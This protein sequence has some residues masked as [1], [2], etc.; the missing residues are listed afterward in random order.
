MVPPWEALFE[1]RSNEAVAARIM[2][3]VIF[4][5]LIARRHAYIFQTVAHQA[6]RDPARDR[7]LHLYLFIRMFRHQA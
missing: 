6:A 1:C 2:V 4:R 5:M 7:G 3:M